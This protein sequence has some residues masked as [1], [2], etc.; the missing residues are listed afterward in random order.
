MT[1]KETLLRVAKNARINLTEEEQK[2]LLP[3][4]QEILELFTKLKEA[5]TKDV[6]PSFHPVELKNKTREDKPKKC[7]GQEEA[8]ANVKHEKDG[9]I[10]GPRIIK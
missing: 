4:L 10:K 2:E 8:L 6:K 9:F 3:Q 7:L 1:D 5:D